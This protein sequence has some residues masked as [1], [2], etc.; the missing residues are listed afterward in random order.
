MLSATG[1]AA[2]IGYHGETNDN[3]GPLPFVPKP[4]HKEMS[5]SLDRS[6]FDKDR[7]SGNVNIHRN[8]S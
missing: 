3:V 7:G 4:Q 1:T 8:D 6:D 2:V 5:T